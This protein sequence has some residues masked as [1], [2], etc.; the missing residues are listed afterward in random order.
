MGSS[1]GEMAHKVI[2]NVRFPLLDPEKL[3]M[4]EVENGIKAYIPVCVPLPP[5]I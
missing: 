3:S 5:P 1:L 4:V 2:Q